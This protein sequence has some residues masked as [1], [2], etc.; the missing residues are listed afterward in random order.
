MFLSTNVFVALGKSAVFA[1]QLLVSR[2]LGWKIIWTAHNLM[3]HENPHP[4]LEAVMMRFF[5]RRCDAVIAHGAAAK[6]AVLKRFEFLSAEKTFVIPH[7][8]YSGYY[9]NRIDRA[10]ARSRLGLPDQAVVFLFFGQL[11]AYKE[12]SHLLMA[13]QELP[14]HSDV[15]LVIAGEP[16]DPALDR[17]IRTQANGDP[18]IH[19]M[20]KFIP[21]DEV[22]LYMNSCDAVVLPYRS[23]TSGVAAL[24]LS[25]GRTCI[26]P[27]SEGTEDS[28]D[29]KGTIFYQAE[30]PDGLSRALRL[31]A[32]GEV[33]LDQ[34]GLHNL[35][36]LKRFEWTEIAARTRSAYV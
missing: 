8:H 34:M 18:R 14:Q 28:L 32:S 26:A 7:G 15:H 3:P 31:A 24:A 13:F 2:L 22:E 10:G 35:T 33:P 27:V 29:E 16:R 6:N 4:R 1:I 21:E 19:Y 30:D 17:A 20:S 5:V 12:V 23:F 36:L 9:A 11:R 25:F